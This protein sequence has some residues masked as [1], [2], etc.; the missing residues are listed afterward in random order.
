MTGAVAE[1]WRDLPTVVAER[2][3]SDAAAG[4]SGAEAAA[5]LREHGPNQ[6]DAAPPVPAWRKLAAQFADPLIYLLIGAV[7]VSLVA[8]VLEGAEDV[9]FEVIVIS[10]IVVA[11]AV[12]GYVQEARAE[13]AVAALQRMAAATTAV[14]RDGREQRVPAVEVVPG[15]VLLLAEG[16]AVTADGRL[17]EAAALTV[18]EAALTGESE[19][20]LKDTAPLEGPVPLATGRT[21]CGAAR[22]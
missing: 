22:P 2:L 16:D 5:R 15:D 1:P 17:L 3:G 20:V 7:V 13:Q 8:W 6:L 9:P 18:S 19:P 21:W 12:L 11:N 10:V 4:L 14:I